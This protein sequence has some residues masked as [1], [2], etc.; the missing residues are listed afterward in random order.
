MK[1]NRESKNKKNENGNTKYLDTIHK[2]YRKTSAKILSMEVL[3]WFPLIYEQVEAL[4]ET[5]DDMHHVDELHHLDVIISFME[6]IEEGK[7][8]SKDCD[9]V[10][11]DLSKDGQREEL[12]I[13]GL[14]NNMVD[15][16][17]GRL[18]GKLV[19]AVSKGYINCDE[20]KDYSELLNSLLFNDINFLIKK[21]DTLT[22]S[23]VIYIEANNKELS[24]LSNFRVGERV[25]LRN[26]EKQPIDYG[27]TA[28]YFYDEYSQKLF[29]IL[30]DKPEAK[31][32]SN[33]E[34]YLSYNDVPA[35]IIEP[36]SGEDIVDA[37]NNVEGGIVIDGGSASKK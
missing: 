9:K 16:A 14:L 37:L 33:R 22:E 28:I 13:I 17:K 32:V 6:E 1:N 8:D 18:L 25:S 5:I 34:I 27:V 23:G 11:N 35:T 21:W 24:R 4:Q 3:K 12:R 29:N 30:T 2:D 20:Y 26:S 10:L 19:V 36:M 15:A 7:L 31:Y